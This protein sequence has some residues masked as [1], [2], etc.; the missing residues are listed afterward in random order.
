MGRRHTLKSFF[1]I[2]TSQPGSICS[3]TFPGPDFWLFT[4]SSAC[5]SSPHLHDNN[6]TGCTGFSSWHGH[7]S[8]E[9]PLVI[10]KYKFLKSFI[11]GVLTFQVFM[12]TERTKHK[13]WIWIAGIQTCEF[14]H[15]ESS[16]CPT[17]RGRPWPRQASRWGR[18]CSEISA[19]C[20]PPVP[21]WCA[22]N[23]G[24]N[25]A[26]RSDRHAAASARSR[27]RSGRRI[28]TASPSSSARTPQPRRQR[29]SPS[30]ARPAAG[31][32][33]CRARGPSPASLCPHRRSAWTICYRAASPC[34]RRSRKSADEGLSETWQLWPR[35]VY[36]PRQK[37]GL[38]NSSD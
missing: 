17:W 27:S 16:P 32:C 22:R 9:V 34:S 31:S 38:T 30:E 5:S 12:S 3:T 8:M 10:H 11:W 15:P 23:T 36:P 7:I 4:A 20:C 2:T 28:S 13:V 14:P 29:H 33:R 25:R 37:H 21:A 6:R 35:Q 18:A 24:W 19:I 1:S 26:R